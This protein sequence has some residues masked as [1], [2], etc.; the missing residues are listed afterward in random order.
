MSAATSHHRFAWWHQGLFLHDAG[1]DWPGDPIE[2]ISFEEWLGQDRSGALTFISPGGALFGASD[3]PLTVE[4]R[5]AEPALDPDAERIADFELSAPSG[6]V[7]LVPSGGA[8]DQAIAI[9]VPAGRWRARWSGFGET[10]A[11]EQ[12]FPSDVLDGPERPDR[13]TLQLWPPAAAQG[14]VIHRA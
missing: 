13:Y 1:Y 5:D 9:E 2:E 3:T 14:V 12:A 10:A 8:D 11:V 4:V 6:R 7:L